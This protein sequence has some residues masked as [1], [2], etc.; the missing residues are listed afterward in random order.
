MLVS[1]G[2]CADAPLETDTGTTQGG[3]N[4]TS[5]ATSESTIEVPTGVGPTSEAT[6]ESTEVDPSTVSSTSSGEVGD[7]PQEPPAS[8][9]KISVLSSRAD[10]VTGGDALVEVRFPPEVA[11]GGVTVL[12]GASDVTGSFEIVDG[13]LL[14]VVEGLALGETV[15]GASAPGETTAELVVTNYP[16]MGPM[17]SGPHQTPFVCRTEESGMG[18]ALD[19][20][21]SA[22]TKY[23]YFY[24][25]IG[26]Q[27][28]PLPDP[29]QVPAD[30]GK[31]APE[32][33][34]MMNYI[35]RVERGTI[36][37]GVYQISA[38]YDP[39]A[40]AWTALTPQAQWNEKVL[41]NFRGGCGEGHHQGVLAAHEDLAGV[42]L[43][44]D[45]PL[46]YGMAV[47]SSTL[48]TLQTNCNDVL[49]SETAMMVKER[50][51]ERYGVPKY[52]MG[53]G[54]SGGS[55]Q[56]HL[57]AENYPGVLDGIV[58]M[59]SY[60]D[61]LSVY[62]D[63]MDCPL[64]LYYL[65]ANAQGMFPD[66]ADFKAVTGY[67]SEQ[68][69]VQWNGPF[70]HFENP[71]I[72]CDPSLPAAQVYHPANNPGGVRCTL[73]DNMKNVLGSDPNTGAGRRIF[74][75]VG[76][77]YGL[78]AL[79]DGAISKAQFL[80]INKGIGGYGKDG[81]AQAAR[82]VAE[83]EGLQAAY[84]GGRV[85][86]GDLGLASV[87]IV[88][89][90]YYTDTSGD[91]H[92]RVRSFSLRER[93]VRANGHFDNHVMVMSTPEAAVQGALAA[94]IGLDAWLV[95][96]A[97]ADKSDLP[98]AVIATKPPVLPSDLCFLD[99][100]MNPTA[101]ACEQPLKVHASPRLIAGAGLHNDTLKCT[102]KPIDPE[103][104][105]V[106]FTAAEM[107]TLQQVF[108]D[109]V[110]DWEVPGVEQVPALGTWQSF[111]PKP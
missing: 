83:T 93:L 82:T 45:I 42:F 97:D 19:E 50:F 70:G 78:A 33:S 71:T 44:N 60:P 25:T 85:V 106:V 96:L 103:D 48:N 40:P 18:P 95:A 14:G 52:T 84:A 3:T 37:R 38:L 101:G 67:A 55:M 99:P 30:V 62:P 81:V 53:W 15:L 72:G 5:G 98:A 63:I 90:R 32:G 57:L 92:D 64:L 108:P 102:L 88:D 107:A 28:M 2:A 77:Q 39:A 66:L 51:V 65:T 110:C 6:S 94:F 73:V 91:I 68:T 11:G 49:T 22:G 100:A 43:L 1:V 59:I 111:G 34:P 46:A 61:T 9:L 24:K 76:V 86:R 54:G 23:E 109:G 56:Q 35:V 12:A 74:D 31:I 87:P 10:M 41:Y 27:F 26:G 80:H 29:T 89:L 20:S 58:P 79:N 69:C 47:L 13:R 7:M 75:N 105:S 36:N 17:I 21:C 8:T 4:V 104:Y 16:V